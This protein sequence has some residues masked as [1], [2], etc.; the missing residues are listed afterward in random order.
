MPR[1]AD[2]GMATEDGNAAV[3]LLLARLLLSLGEETTAERLNEEYEQG[4]ELIGSLHPEAWS[5]YVRMR[6]RAEFGLA[7]AELGKG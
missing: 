3:G 6:V 4:M 2:F 7:L 5:P 1:R